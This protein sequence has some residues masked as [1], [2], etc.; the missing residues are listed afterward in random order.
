V[1]FGVVQHFQHQNQQRLLKEPRLGAA[2]RAELIGDVVILDPGGPRGVLGVDFWN[3]FRVA[4]LPAPQF[5]RPQ[6]PRIARNGSSNGGE[7]KHEH[8]QQ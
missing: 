4:S 5:H 8:E 2:Y 6:H 1:T 7:K 3:R